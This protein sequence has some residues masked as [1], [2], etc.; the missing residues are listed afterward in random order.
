MQEESEVP[1]CEILTRCLVALDTDPDQ[2]LQYDVLRSGVSGAY[3]YR[4][5][6]LSRDLVLKVTLRESPTY[7]QERA[8]R[9]MLFYRNL[10][11]SI[12]IQVPSVIAMRSDEALGSSI[13]LEAYEPSPP[14]A[15]WT[16]ARYIM[17]AEQ[18]GCFHAAF[19][20]SAEELANYRWL[21]KIGE[22]AKADVQQAYT[23]WERLSTERRFE[24]VLTRECQVWI[25]EMLGHIHDVE[26]AMS[27]FP[28]TLCHGD[29]HIDN[30]LAD[31]N[32]DLVIADW[33]EVGLGRGPEDLSF[34]LQRASFS[35][36]AVP[37]EDMV[38]AYQRTL[39]ANMGEDMRVTDIRRVV[40]AAELRARL[41]HWPAFLTAASKDQVA[42]ILGRIRAIADSLEL[43]LAAGS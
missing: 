36:G 25:R 21:R 5:R 11:H 8:C 41:L 23:Y 32:G 17:V 37:A 9:E 10:A 15:A 20:G 22:V 33:Q 4:L 34:F 18:L 12:Q 43:P 39:A 16:E 2:V 6:F 35:G 30:I 29:F 28:V 27:G 7:V 1:H 26:A 3:V 14:P 19:W 42:D 40:D 24:R 38:R 31:P 13:L